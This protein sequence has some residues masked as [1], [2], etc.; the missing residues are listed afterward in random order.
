MF[1]KKRLLGVDIGTSSVKVVELSRSGQQYRIEAFGIESFPEE[2]LENRVP[3]DL[4]NIVVAIRKAVRLSGTRLRHAAAAVPTSSVVIR[5]SAYSKALGEDELE[6]TVQLDAPNQI[7]F[8][9]D[10]GYLDFQPIGASRNR[11]DM[12]DVRLVACR[13]ENVDW[14]REAIQEAGLKPVVIDVEAYALENTFRLLA[15]GLTRAEGGKKSTVELTKLPVAKESL[16]TALVDI[17]AAVTTIYVLQGADVVFNREQSFGGSRLT[18]AVAET[19]GLPKDRAELAKRSGELSEDYP[20]TILL[21]FEQEVIDQISQALQF[22][23]NA[24]HYSNNSVGHII[25]LGGGSM[26][27]GL[28]KAISERLEIPTTVANPFAHMSSASRVNRHGLLRDAPLF[29]VACGLA[30]RSF[31]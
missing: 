22:F 14:R 1:S 2:T 9:L 18:A 16:T 5:T 27:T 10:Q 11:E 8:P 29:A 17:G 25:L 28:E 30:L 20:T 24:G 13:K 12:Q 6:A 15:Q 26:I 31:E 4:D 23:S 7:P 19:Y 3:T 21:P